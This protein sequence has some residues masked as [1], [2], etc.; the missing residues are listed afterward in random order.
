MTSSTIATSSHGS[1]KAARLERSPHNPVITGIGIVSPIGTGVAKFWKSAV[2]G[3]SGVDWI[4]GADV[5][6]LPQAC[7][8]VGQVRDFRANDWMGGMHGKMAGRF[9]QFAVA[10][11]R[12]AI[13][14]SGLGSAPIPAERIKIG[15]GSSIS[16][17]MDLHESSFTSFLQGG[18]I[19]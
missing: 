10:A 12:M 16:G 4:A 13:E 8:I 17:L 1:L 15:F 7:R 5:S 6:N 2:A 11:T 9:S 14:D 18:K 3:R 19:L